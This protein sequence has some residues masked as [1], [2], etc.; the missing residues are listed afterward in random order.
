MAKR[1]KISFNFMTSMV[2]NI[3]WT[4]LKY[5]YLL[6]LFEVRH[7]LRFS[8]VGQSILHDDDEHEMWLHA[9]FH[10]IS[11]GSCSLFHLCS[12][13]IQTI[14]TTQDNA[15]WASLRTEFFFLLPIRLVWMEIT[16]RLWIYSENVETFVIAHSIVD[17]WMH[18]SIVRIVSNSKIG[19]KCIN[20]VP[21]TMYKIVNFVQFNANL[22]TPTNLLFLIPC[23]GLKPL[24][25]E[26]L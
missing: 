8:R 23:C 12:E 4:A 17:S 14:L 25:N 2:Q 24:T 15:T 21:I 20:N 19:V 3:K 11:G 10:S 26:Q 18:K 7:L 9:Q 13:F 16:K 1:K 22:F 6:P 5:R